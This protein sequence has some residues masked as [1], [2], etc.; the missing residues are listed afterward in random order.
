MRS[1]TLPD[2]A[3]LVLTVMALHGPLALLDMQSL[4][5]DHF[6]HYRWASQFVENIEAGILR[7]HWEATSRGGLGDPVFL[8]YMPGF[9]YVVYLAN[10]VLGDVWLSMK[11]VFLLSSLLAGI[12][13][14]RLARGLIPS[15]PLVYGV[16][17]IAIAAPVF[18][19]IRGYINAY[20]WYLAS[21]VLLFAAVYLVRC[22]QAGGARNHAMLAACIA[23]SSLI[24]TLSTLTFLSVAGFG[25]A[26]EWAFAG[27]GLAF[28]AKALR[29]AGAI[30]IGIAISAYAL[31]PALGALD[32]VS[33]E[34]FLT[35]YGAHWSNTFIFPV[36]TPI[37][38]IAVSFVMPVSLLALLAAALWLAMRLRPLQAEERVLIAAALVG[39][40]LS[41]EFSYPLWLYIEPLQFVQRPFRY[42]MP[43]AVTLAPLLI[44]LVGRAM[45]A[46]AV[47]RANVSVFAAVGVA[48]AVLLA[49]HAKT[50]SEIRHRPADFAGTTPALREEL[51]FTNEHLPAGAG[52]G[53][54]AFLEAGGWPAFCQANGLTCAEERVSPEHFRWRIETETA[55][56]VKLPLMAFPAWALTLDG[57][58]IP[59]TGDPESGLI[60]VFLPAGAHA[61]EAEWRRLPIEKS[62]LAIS[63][64][65][66][67]ALLG[68]GVLGLRRSPRG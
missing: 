48:V 9:Y 42:L 3:F 30:L 33:P 59:L 50:Y 18:L 10:A 55:Q 67:L 54:K 31:L 64:V 32:L 1:R 56:T 36:V 11:A 37:Y 2:A 12:G 21:V 39:F 35:T 46:G 24:H 62:G 22:L 63:A 68:L 41:V 25:V 14:L 29:L 4:A 57:A 26:L 17:F 40:F 13:V 15:K 52:D 43:V 61:I 19:A 16:T 5:T 66:L 44:L 27:F 28:L 60:A 34:N 51:Y 49:L 38:R 7:P 20:P 23:A 47:K 45:S 6:I 58:S 65:G 53:W 8:Y